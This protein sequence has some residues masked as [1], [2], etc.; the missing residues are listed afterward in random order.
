MK[1]LTNISE[2]SDVRRDP[3]AFDL[4][5]GWESKVVSIYIYVNMNAIF[6]VIINQKCSLIFLLCL[7]YDE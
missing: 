2:A 4:P 6:L 7:F 3:V 5:M 1:I